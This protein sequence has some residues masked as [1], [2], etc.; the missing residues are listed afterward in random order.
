MTAAGLSGSAP[1]AC[2][3]GS[4]SDL[5]S[6]RDRASAM[7]V[8]SLGPLI[9][10]SSTRH[11]N[12]STLDLLIVFRTC[13]WTGRRWLHR[14]DDWGKIYLYCHSKFVRPYYRQTIPYPCLFRFLRA[15]RPHRYSI[16][17]R[18]VCP[19]HPPQTSAT[20]G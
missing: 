1:I 14:S 7:A 18:N 19:Y 10:V 12:Y 6:E 15:R 17:E 11:S 8:Y 9:G 20:I 2:G 13:R 16:A 4:I 3:G 5:F